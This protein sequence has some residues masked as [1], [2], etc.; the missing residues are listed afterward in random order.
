MEGVWPENSTL[1]G[2]EFSLSAQEA[3]LLRKGVC[4][5]GERLGSQISNFPLSVSQVLPPSRVM[6]LSFLPLSLILLP[7][8]HCLRVSKRARTGHCSCA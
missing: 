2:A 1:E 3:L 4:G 5:G 7:S 8:Q 6:M